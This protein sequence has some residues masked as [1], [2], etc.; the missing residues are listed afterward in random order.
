MTGACYLCLMGALRSGSG[1]VTALVPSSIK[2][3][4]SILVPEAIVVPV[5]QT[6]KGNLSTKALKDILS[7]VRRVDVIA[8]G[9]GI[10]QEKQTINLVNKIL[11]HI[12]VPIVVDADA[13]NIISKNIGILNKVKP[14]IVLTPHPGEMSRLLKKSISQIQ[15]DRE[16]LAREF[17]AHFKLTLVL[18]GNKTIVAGNDEIY[19]NSTGNCGMATAGAGDVLTGMISS[20]IGQGLDVFD[21]SMLAVYIHGLSGDIV[22]D[23]KTDLSLI[24]RDLIDEIPSA[25]KKIQQV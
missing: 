7:Y 15:A 20:F 9:P 17:A 18:K 13:I 23:K 3:A 10:G 4:I 22:K 1:L 19:I 11:T 6:E 16:D 25:I 2:P 5:P 8:L 14:Y 24:A 21:A 12:K